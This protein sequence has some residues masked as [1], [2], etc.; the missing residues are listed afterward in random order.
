[1]RV[2]ATDPGE[3]RRR[4][5]PVVLLVLTFTTG[6]VDAISY[7]GLGGIF[8]A[9]QT[10]NLVL[11]GFAVAGTEGFAIEPPALSLV[12]FIAGATLGGRWAR[13]LPDR[14]RRW[15]SIALATEAALVGLAIVAAGGLDAATLADRQLVVIALLGLA[16]GLRSATVT[17]LVVPGL[18][19]TVM[20][21]TISTMAADLGQAG[22]G[23]GRRRWMLATIVAR[24]LGAAGGALLLEVSGILPLLL[25]AGLVAAC[26]LAYV[27]PVVVRSVLRGHRSRQKR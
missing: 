2:G 6:L 17:Q 14:H 21:S 7:L 3:P 24:V 26:A 20:T 4:E 27:M 9:F 13:H 15:F 8:T 16:M 22:G 19:T 5:L 25:V 1:M 11:L 23:G 12:G 18:T 10:G